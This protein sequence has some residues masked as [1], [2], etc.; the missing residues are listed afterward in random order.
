MPNSLIKELTTKR[1][2]ISKKA[3]YLGFEIYCFCLCIILF[4][5]CRKYFYSVR[6][7]AV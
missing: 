2:Q 1:K 7:G 4:A 3:V 5:K 6:E